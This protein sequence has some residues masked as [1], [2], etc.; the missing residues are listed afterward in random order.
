LK[1]KLLKVE[2]TIGIYNNGSDIILQEINVDAIPFNILKTIVI[3][4]NDDPLLY[5]MY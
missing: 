4:N 1:A 2:R 3:P 5:D